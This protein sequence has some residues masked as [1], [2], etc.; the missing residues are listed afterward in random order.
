MNKTKIEWCDYVINPIKGL[1]PVG[2]SYCYARRMYKRFKWNPKIEFAPQVFDDVEK[3]KKPSRIFVGSTME[4]FGDYFDENWT[5]YCLLTAKKKFPQH[6]FIFL[7]KRP[8]NLAKWSPFPDN[9]WVGVSAT[10]YK[11]YGNVLQY[12]PD[13]KAK[14]KFVSF[15]PLLTRINVVERLEGINWLLIGQQTP[16]SVKTIPKVEWVQEIVQAADTAGAPVFLKNNLRAVFANN[17]NP[18]DYIYP[19]WAQDSRCQL[20]QEF[21]EVSA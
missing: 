13:I 3:I 15:E 19:L 4:L 21:P 5:E 9:C 6:T 2:C 16:A 7:T 12:F 18:S 8:E 20:R 11:Q 1:C 10:D 17:K 14:V